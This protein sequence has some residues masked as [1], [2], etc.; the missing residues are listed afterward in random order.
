MSKSVPSIKQTRV[1]KVCTLWTHDDSFS[2]EDI[3]FNGEKFPEIRVRP[4]SLLQIVAINPGTAV[5]DFQPTAKN[6]QTEAAQAR[7]E[8]ANRDNGGDSYSKRSRRGSLTITVDENGSTLLG[9]REVDV[10][11]AYIF[12]PKPLPADLK[13]KHANLQVRRVR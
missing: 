8:Y 6:T 2:R 9:G 3:I 10:E 12:A 11:K 13:A 7:G 5:R 1:Q 4:G